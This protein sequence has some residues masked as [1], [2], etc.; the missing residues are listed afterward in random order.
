MKESLVYTLVCVLFL[1]SVS[2]LIAEPGDLTQKDLAYQVIEDDRTVS[3]AYY[4]PDYLKKLE[5]E[6]ATVEMRGA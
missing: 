1:V 6:K 5:E 2:S 3:I 4:G